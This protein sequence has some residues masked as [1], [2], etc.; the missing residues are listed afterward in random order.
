MNYAKILSN[1]RSY[2]ELQESIVLF[3]WIVHFHDDSWLK[4]DILL[5]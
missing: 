3:T 5:S 1:H 2:I 4:I